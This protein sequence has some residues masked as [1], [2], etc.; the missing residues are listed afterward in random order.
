MKEGEELRYEITYRN[1]TGSKQTATI[2]DRVPQY[3]TFL[4]ADNGGTESNGTITW[5][6]EVENGQSWTVRFRVKVN[7]DVNGKPVDNVARVRDGVNAS[8]TNQTHNPTPVKPT[9][10]SPPKK[11]VKPTTPSTPGTPSAPTVTRPVQIATPKTGDPGQISVPLYGILL[12]ASL[13]AMAYIGWRIRK[14]S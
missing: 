5:V 14:R 1:T 7:Q 8:E 11:P 12:F 9:P 10:P 3:T 2:T 4:S 6:R 13:G